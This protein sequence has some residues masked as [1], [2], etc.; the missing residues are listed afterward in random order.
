MS[1][2]K[3]K[4]DRHCVGGRQRSATTKHFAD[5]IFTGYKII[6]G[7]CSDSNRK[8]IMTVSGN[9]ITAEVLGD[10]FKNLG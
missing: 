4:T 5:E 1:F 7:H 8:K 3:I 10:L 9:T 6:V 2:Q